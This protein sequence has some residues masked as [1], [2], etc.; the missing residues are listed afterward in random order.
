M[1]SAAEWKGQRKEPVN[2]KIKPQKS[3]NL[4][5]EKQTKKKK[6]SASG[7]SGTTGKDLTFA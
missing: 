4:N 1:I 2:L 3:P 5:R 7:M 6:K